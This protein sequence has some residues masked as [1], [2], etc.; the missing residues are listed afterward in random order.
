MFSGLVV[1]EDKTEICLFYKQDHP[2][3]E[4]SL[5]GKLIKSQKTIN[6]LGV[7]FDSKMQWGNQ[8]AMA[9]SKSKRALHGIRLIKKFLTKGE[10]MMLLTSNFYSILYY[11]C[12]IWLSNGLNIRLKQKI[13]SASSHALLMLNNSSDMRISFTQLHKMEKEPF[14]WNLRNIGLPFSSSKFTME[15][16]WT[17][18]GLTW[19]FNR[20]LMQ[21]KI[22]STSQTHQDS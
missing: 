11:N 22:T 9:I 1:N 2:L 16:Q 6:V 14:Q 13:V 3:V 12:E 7:T 20:I 5:F 21:D 10:T 8:V 4:L 15:P 19:I 17:M 18:I